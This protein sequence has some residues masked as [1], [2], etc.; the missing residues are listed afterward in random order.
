V[1]HLC[2]CLL[3]LVR[4]GAHCLQLEYFTQ[5]VQIATVSNDFDAE[6]STAAKALLSAGE[7]PGLQRVTARVGLLS[8]DNPD[9]AVGE[10]LSTLPTVIATTTDSSND[11]LVDVPA[12]MYKLC[13]S[14]SASIYA[15]THTATMDTG[16]SLAASKHAVLECEADGSS[17]A[18]QREYG[19]MFECF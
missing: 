12:V 6:P 7:T 2:L 17:A 8:L 14:G 1:L 16:M 4:Y 9:I 11:R 13:H 18:M 19:S 15:V 3:L 10:L 5:Q